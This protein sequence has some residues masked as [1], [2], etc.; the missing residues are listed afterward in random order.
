MYKVQ[1]EWC[2]WELRVGPVVKVPT[3][4]E[5]KQFL[6]ARPVTADQIRAIAYQ[7]M[8]Q[9]IATRCNLTECEAALAIGNMQDYAPHEDM[10]I[11]TIYMV[12]NW[13]HC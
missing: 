2:F 3:A 11:G 9:E 5:L 10:A 12:S 4:E 6:P 8:R 7:L 1:G 13:T